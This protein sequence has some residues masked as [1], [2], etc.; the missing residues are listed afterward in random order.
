M[1]ETQKE[2]LNALVAFL[3]ENNLSFEQ[4]YHSNTFGLDMAIKVKKLRIA[5]FLSEG[6]ERDGEIVHAPSLTKPG[7][8]LVNMY[9]P[10]FIRENETTE[11]II[12]KMQNCI[13]KRMLWQQKRWQKKHK[14]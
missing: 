7:K 14:N 10:F 6:Q 13:I 5:V 3:R 4:N 12:E 9:N 11:F 1:K 8:T 2:K